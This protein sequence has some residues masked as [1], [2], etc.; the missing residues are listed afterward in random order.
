M[1]M[2]KNMEIQ[3]GVL[4][5]EPI[6][7]RKIH[8]P[9]E[10]FFM[11]C[12]SSPKQKWMF[13]KVSEGEDKG[14]IVHQG[15]GK[16]LSFN[17]VKESTQDSRYSKVKMLSFLSNI[18]NDIGLTIETPVMESCEIDKSSTRYQSQIWSL[19]SPVNFNSDL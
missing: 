2:T 10:S 4:C 6:P 18:V 9:I 13:L 14:K 12:N 19:D 17:K 7:S 11:P 3:N 5:L 1:L 15:T 8:E 16:C